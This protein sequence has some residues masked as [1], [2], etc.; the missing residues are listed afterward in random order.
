MKKL[1]CALVACVFGLIACGSAD[2]QEPNKT[3]AV[4]QQVAPQ[5]FCIQRI[6]CLRGQGYCCTSATCV[7]INGCLGCDLG[8]TWDRTTCTC[9]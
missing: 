1:V 6:Q 3:D 9:R 8:Q 7:E 5:T 4:D 2:S